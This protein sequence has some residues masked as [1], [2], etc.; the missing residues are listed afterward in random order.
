M[1]V[2][3]SWGKSCWDGRANY[4]W[5]LGVDIII[6]IKLGFL[7]N[8]HKSRNITGTDLVAV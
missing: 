3:L 7:K 2:E 5:G 1:R 8:C 6:I 4:K